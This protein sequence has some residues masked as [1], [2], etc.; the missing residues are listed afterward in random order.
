MRLRIGAL[1]GGRKTFGGVFILPH[2]VKKR[3]DALH[4]ISENI[5]RVFPKNSSRR[6]GGEGCEALRTPGARR[7][8]ANDRI[9]AKFFTQGRVLPREK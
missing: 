6:R 3:N 1:W 2:D 4:K 8:K 5:K 7:R 9:I